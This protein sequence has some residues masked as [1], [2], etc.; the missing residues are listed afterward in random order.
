M[1]LHLQYQCLLKVHHLSISTHLLHRASV[2]VRS[3]LTAAGDLVAHGAIGGRGHLAK[4][5]E[6][7]EHRDAEV[8]HGILLHFHDVFQ[9][10]A[11]P[12][13]ET[14]GAYVQ[15]QPGA[16]KPTPQG[17]PERT[18]STHRIGVGD[19]Y[20]WTAK[21]LEEHPF[22][23]VALADAIVK[24][25]TSASWVVLHALVQ[26]A[27]VHDRCCDD[28]EVHN[29]KGDLNEQRACQTAHVGARKAADLWP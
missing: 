25:V 23:L 26:L 12:H 15:R 9:A 20:H 29:S 18:D 6:R 10:Q 11:P 17:L 2:A 4:T 7:A 16:A 27:H 19:A 1:T 8:I 24:I 22:V 14:E 3:V 21:P 5:D 28:A 13:E